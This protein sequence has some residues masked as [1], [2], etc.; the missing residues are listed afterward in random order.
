VLSG[1]RQGGRLGIW[2]KPV[3]VLEM[4]APS[5][6]VTAI[7]SPV[8]AMESRVLD[9]LKKWP[10]APV[11]IM[12]VGFVGGEGVDCVGVTLPLVTAK[13][14]IYFSFILIALVQSQLYRIPSKRTESH[15]IQRLLVPLYCI[16]M[17]LLGART[18]LLS[19][20]KWGFHTFSHPYGRCVG[21]ATM[22]RTTVVKTHG[23][24]RE[25]NW[26]TV[27]PP[28]IRHLPLDHAC[29]A[30]FKLLAEGSGVTGPLNQE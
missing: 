28:T 13:L 24:Q 2:S 7:L 10:V 16:L 22:V 15:N 9:V 18:P 11:L 3:C 17:A 27:E 23:R 19:L 20:G 25:L 1:R 6:R 14:L 4:M 8:T 21:K 26:T 29:S 12:V 5:E 30:A